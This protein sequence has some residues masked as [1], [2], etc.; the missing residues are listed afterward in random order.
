MLSLLW[1]LSKGQSNSISFS[2]Q[3]YH[4]ASGPGISCLPLLLLPE[5]FFPPAWRMEDRERKRIPYS[6]YLYK[7]VIV[8]FCTLIHYSRVIHSFYSHTKL[9][10]STKAYRHL[11]CPNTRLQKRKGDGNTKCH[12]GQAARSAFHNRARRQQSLLRARAHRPGRRGCRVAETQ[13]TCN[14]TCHFL[15][16]RK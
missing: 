4:S 6:M 13:S 14:Y 11:R 1:S 3:L 5:Q 8:I 9:T 15:L 7:D 10:K 16:C 2:V 12:H